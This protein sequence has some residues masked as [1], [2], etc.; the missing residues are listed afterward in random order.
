MGL[1]DTTPRTPASVLYLQF[2]SDQPSQVH[3]SLSAKPVFALIQ[4]LLFAPKCLYGFLITRYDGVEEA[5][6]LCFADRSFFVPSRKPT[7]N[8]EVDPTSESD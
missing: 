7:T 3:N 1:E 4:I 2:H 8:L 6:T 5:S